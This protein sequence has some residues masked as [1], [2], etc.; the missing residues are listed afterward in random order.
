M[1]C[2]SLFATKDVNSLGFNGLF[3]GEGGPEHFWKTLVATGG[4]IIYVC[5]FS[6]ICFFITNFFI[7]F[8]ATDMEM[9]LGLDVSKHGERA[10]GGATMADINSS[11]H[12]G[13]GYAVEDQIVTVN[14]TDLK[15][16]L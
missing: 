2:T 6:Y 8:R 10:I 9:L 3:Y 13:G 16:S 4:M 14:P 12:Q 11:V 1:I 15:G 5:T 7:T